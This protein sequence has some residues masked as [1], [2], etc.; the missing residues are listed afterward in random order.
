M[1]RAET[2]VWR[3]TLFGEFFLNL[4]QSGRGRKWLKGSMFD[5]AIRF[6]VAIALSRIVT[7]GTICE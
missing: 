5:V 6:G 2:P 1:N 3:E 7:V 4:V